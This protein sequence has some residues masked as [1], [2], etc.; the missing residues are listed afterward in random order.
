MKWLKLV[1]TALLFSPLSACE[2]RVQSESDP[3][4]AGGEVNYASSAQERA[5]ETRV[6][7]EV[8]DDEAEQRDQRPDEEVVDTREDET[9]EEREPERVDPDPSGAPS[10]INLGWIGGPCEDVMDCDYEEGVCLDATEGLPE[11]HCSQPCELYCPDQDGAATTFCVNPEDLGIDAVGGWCAM[12]CDFSMSPTGCREGYHCA[13]IA[14]FGQPETLKFAC[15]P[16]EGEALPLS[17]CMLELAERGVGFQIGQNPMD[18]PD[19][20]PDL[21][22]DVQDPV[23][24]DGTMAGVNYR[25][26]SATGDVKRIFAA[27][28][29]ALAMHDTATLVAAEGV[30]DIIHL[31]VYNCRVISGTSKLSEHAHANAIDISG[32]RLNDGTIWTVYDDWE[33]GV[34]EPITSAGDWL[35]W[36]ANELHIQ[37]IFNIILTPEYNAAHDDHFHADLTP[38]AHSLH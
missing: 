13:S 10:D 17:D 24:V 26:A 33:D 12:Q 2:V 27:C 15:M 29:L 11:G 19:G 1:L 14:R 7:I 36:F 37:W 4:S 38:G 28:E 25:Y 20:H 21:V 30:S 16:G 18:S 35:L 8:P 34:E 23:W 6:V 32:F 22:C 31:G 9:P 5:P 3:Q